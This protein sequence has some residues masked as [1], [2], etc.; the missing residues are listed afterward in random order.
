MSR[1]PS[2]R[3]HK[4]PKNLRQP[5]FC[6]V[7]ATIE[8]S[9]SAA[10]KVLDLFH[11][12]T[13]HIGTYNG[14][15]VVRSFSRRRGKLEGFRERCGTIHHESRGLFRIN[16]LRLF[17]CEPP[18]YDLIH[19]IQSQKVRRSKKSSR[20]RVIR[21]PRRPF[22]SWRLSLLRRPPSLIVLAGSLGSGRRCDR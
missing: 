5:W 19:K 2:A 21:Q 11:R 22:A 7:E 14:L 13:G 6:P 18:A 8:L 16:F 20:S 9:F 4:F 1:R 12:L 15:I 17:C 3:S 10:E